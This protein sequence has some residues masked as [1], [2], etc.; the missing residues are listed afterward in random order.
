MNINDYRNINN[1]NDT[2]EKTSL[3]SSKISSKN[4]SVS[5]KASFIVYHKRMEIQNKLLDKDFV[6][7]INNPQLLYNKSTKTF[8]DNKVIG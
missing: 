8:Y 4:T 7:S 5:S 3:I 1:Y 6:E 2:K